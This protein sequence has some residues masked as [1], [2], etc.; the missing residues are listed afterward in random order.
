MKMRIFCWLAVPIF[1]GVA[2][3]FVVKG[4]W[5]RARPSVSSPDP[6]IDYPAKVDLGE[7]EM[8]DQVVGRF[9]IANRGGGELIVD[10]IRTN[11]SCS[12]MEQEKDGRFFR[13]DS[14]R[15]NAGEQADLVMRVAVRG[16]PVGTE[17]LNIVEF[18]TNDPTHPTGRME[19]VVRRVWGGVSTNPPSVIFGAAP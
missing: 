6:M 18:Q 8:G 11:C 2:S 10:Q 12:G 16:V 9:T 3:Y 1:L 4:Q 14:L 19:V 15:L 7:C 5:L 13:I 17:M